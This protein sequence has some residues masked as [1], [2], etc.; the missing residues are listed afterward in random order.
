MAKIY[1]GKEETVELIKEII[2]TMSDGPTDVINNTL[3]AKAKYLLQVLENGIDDNNF[4]TPIKIVSDY[5]RGTKVTGKGYLFVC[6]YNRYFCSIYV[7]GKPI[8]EFASSTIE[9][10]YHTVAEKIPFKNSVEVRTD[11]DPSEDA[12]PI[13]AVCY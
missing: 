8:S 9:R 4:G 2:G 10:N 5:K 6:G 1:L 13:V 12:A 7:D 3:M 11:L